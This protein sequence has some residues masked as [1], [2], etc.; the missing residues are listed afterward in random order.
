MVTFVQFV[1]YLLVL[2]VVM[3]WLVDLLERRQ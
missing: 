1:I 3:S 2:S